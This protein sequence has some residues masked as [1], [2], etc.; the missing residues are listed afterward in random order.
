MKNIALFLALSA[1]VCSMQ[2]QVPVKKDLMQILEKIPPPPVSVREAFAKLNCE[3]S[4]G[5]VN[6]S[7]ARLFESTDVVL[8]DVEDAYKAQGKAGNAPLPPGVSPEMARKAQD[9]EMK[10]KMKGMS[11]E[12][13]MKMAVEM[14]GSGSAGVPV[15]EVDPPLVREALTEWMKVNE[16]IQTEFQRSVEEQQE[17]VRKSTEDARGHDEISAWEEAEIQKLPRISSGEMSA[18][19]PAKVK[20]VHLNAIDRHVAYADKKL[21]QVQQSWLASLQ[22]VKT[23]FAVFHQKLVA[24]DYAAVSKNFSTL[25]VLS[26]A[27]IMILK[28]V[29]SLVQRSRGAY[30]K[31]GRWLA[32]RKVIEHQ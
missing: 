20:A 1:I 7:A 2:A 6:C 28:E 4:S 11:K 30:E 31:S 9:P 21:G 18:P 10:K 23:R 26:D 24:A 32:V 15:Q 8:K 19:D 27:Q 22:Q 17:E 3:E 14:M 29:T 16:A 25:K 12:E 5:S 13:K